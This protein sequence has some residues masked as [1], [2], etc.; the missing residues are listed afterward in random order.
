MKYSILYNRIFTWLFF[1]KRLVS[2]ATAQRNAINIIDDAN[3]KGSF[4][5]FTLALSLNKYTPPI[6][7]DEMCWC[8]WSV[9]FVSPNVAFFFFSLVTLLFV[10]AIHA[11]E[12][13]SCMNYYA[14]LYIIPLRSMPF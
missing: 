4:N 2:A 3:Q 8:R 13:L 10:F 12:C 11:I 9:V 14:Q 7:L 5:L 6:Y 1:G